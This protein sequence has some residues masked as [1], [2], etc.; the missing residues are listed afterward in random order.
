MQEIFLANTVFLLIAF[1]F[2]S[3]LFLFLVFFIYFRNDIS[4]SYI[5]AAAKRR[6]IPSNLWN[7]FWLP[8]FDRPILA[9]L[10]YRFNFHLGNRHFGKLITNF[11][12]FL[13]GVEIYYNAKIGRAFQLWHGQGTVIGQNAVIGENCIMLNQVTLGAGFVVIGDNVKIG[14]GARVLGT[15]KVGDGCVIGANCVVNHDLPANTMVKLRCDTKEIPS[16][17]CITFGTKP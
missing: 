16:S 9:L 15:L 10:I 6:N 1:L 4:F 11:G 5:D 8:I 14:V 12:F 2:L 7:F 3:C 17:A 13:T